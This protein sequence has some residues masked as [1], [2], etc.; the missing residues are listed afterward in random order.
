VNREL[1]HCSYCDHAAVVATTTRQENAT[2]LGC[3]ST[4]NDKQIMDC[5]TGETDNVVFYIAKFSELNAN[6]AVKKW[7]P[8]GPSDPNFSS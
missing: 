4:A 7:A 2:S 8:R 1:I 3:T 6:N 5:G